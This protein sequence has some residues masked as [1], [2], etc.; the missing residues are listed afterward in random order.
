MRLA[1]DSIERQAWPKT[2]GGTSSVDAALLDAGYSSSAA[3]GSPGAYYG[4]I[5]I[6]YTNFYYSIFTSK[7]QKRPRVFY[8][9]ALTHS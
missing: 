3:V 9:Y 2:T 4:T 8:M 5:I 1:M 7:G 6:Y